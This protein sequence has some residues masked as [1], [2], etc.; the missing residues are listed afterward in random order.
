M[1]GEEEEVESDES[2]NRIRWRRKGEGVDGE[3]EEG[4][5]EWMGRRK[6]GRVGG[7]EEVGGEWVGRRKRE[8]VGRGRE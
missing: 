4:G 2:K 7:E 1:K 8:G 3:E 5:R 6:R